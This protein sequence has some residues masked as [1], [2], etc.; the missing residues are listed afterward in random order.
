MNEPPKT[1]LIFRQGRAEAA[2]AIRAL[3]RKALA[4]WI[5]VI[6]Q[7][8]IPM[9]ADY[10]E[11]IQNNRFDLLLEN[12]A[13]VAL[14]ETIS[15]GDHLLI[16]NIA[17]TP[18]CQGC[19]IGRKLLQFVET[20]AVSSELPEIKLH[21]N[22]AFAENLRLCEKEGYEVEREEDFMGGICVHM[23]KAV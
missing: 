8:P 1:N 14:I 20:L 22:K 2:A 11:A 19:G 6:G 13:L 10:D 16:E 21:T 23:R 9:R 3:T 15:R 5:S 4:K 17:V 12:G 18:N 7:E